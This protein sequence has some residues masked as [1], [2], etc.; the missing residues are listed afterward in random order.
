M[1]YRDLNVKMLNV[2]CKV[3]V[4]VW[5]SWK[6]PKYNP[7]TKCMNSNTGIVTM[8]CTVLLHYCTSDITAFIVFASQEDFEADE[9][10]HAA[11]M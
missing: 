9:N 4:C 7:H 1:S 5:V 8:T 6:M 10:W 11:L 3:C 2:K